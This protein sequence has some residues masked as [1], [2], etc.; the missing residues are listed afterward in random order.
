MGACWAGRPDPE[1]PP[2]AQRYTP[3]L[4]APSRAHAFRNACVPCRVVRV[5]D[6]DTLQVI[7]RATDAEPWALYSVRLA[8]V[9]TPELRGA[10]PAERAAAEFVATYVKVIVGAPHT[11]TAKGSLCCTAGSDKFGRLLGDVRLPRAP[12]GVGAHLLT[13]G[14]GRAYTGGTKE[15]WTAADL[16]AVTTRAKL[17]PKNVGAQPR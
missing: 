1:R 9:D 16:P 3:P 15:P 7:T 5:I 17:L 6:G 13:A 8:G 14:L 4:S 10:T 11:E 12:L 2:Q